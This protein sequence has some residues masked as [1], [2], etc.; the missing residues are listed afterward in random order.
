MERKSIGQ[1]IA[2]LRK[3]NGLTQKQ[4]ADKLNV[5]DKAI[6]RWERDETA[7]DISLI[8]II[9]DIFGVTCDELLC[10]ERKINN[11]NSSVSD[12]V[13]S[14]KGEKQRRRI[15]TVGLSQFKNRSIIS[16]AISAVGLIAALICNFAFNRAHLGFY[17][18]LIFYLVALVCQ[19]IFIN[20]AFLSVADDE[21][22]DNEIQSHKRSVV[23]V[24]EYA[25]SVIFILFVFTLPLV[26]T[27]VGT[28]G[29]YAGELPEMWFGYGAIYGVVGLIICILTSFKI[30]SSLA[31]K[32]IITENN[33]EKIRRHNFY[34]GLICAVSLAVVIFLTFGVYCAVTDE[35][36]WP[37]FADGIIFED[38]NSFAE[39]M[40][41]EVPN[42][43]MNFYSDNASFSIE[44]NIETDYEDYDYFELDESS[45]EY[46]DIYIESYFD[47]VTYGIY[48]DSIRIVIKD[49]DGY[50][51]VDCV[52]MND[53]VVSIEY[54][55]E[56]DG[57]LPIKVVTMD[58]SIIGQQRLMYVKLAF[59]A[60]YIL[61]AGIAVFVY[62]KKREKLTK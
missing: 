35:G 60:V 42:P 25:I 10:G 30:N 1:F 34:L 61:E 20:K 27:P 13:L 31:K 3:A 48:D 16:S 41:K 28:V 45:D 15:L 52:R 43:G 24:A 51:V 53:S 38:Y 23:R 12:E 54:G 21:F 8:P 22:S 57:F 2:A 55:D 17:I 6:S 14:A 7:P 50:T 46:Y 33:N 59:L 58:E 9:A 19:I 39:Y 40:E 37:K 47:E 26:V 44:E 11:E 5:S 29:N 18:A 62:F 49:V 4:L 56:K 36:Y 32:G